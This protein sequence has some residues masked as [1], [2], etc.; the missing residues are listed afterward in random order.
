MFAVVLGLGNKIDI[1]EA[2]SKRVARDLA[3]HATA[4]GIAAPVE[5]DAGDI[6]PLVPA[7]LV[8]QRLQSR[9]IGAGFRAEH[10]VAGLP[11]CPLAVHAAGFQRLPAG[12]NVRGNRIG[13]IRLIQQ[14]NGAD[15][16]GD[17]IH[18]GRERVAEQSGDAKGDIDARPLQFGKRGDSK[19]R[20][21]AGNFF[22]QRPR[23]DQRQYLRHVVAAGA[24]VRG[25]PGRQRDR[26]RPFA[27]LL[28]VS[29]HQPLRGQPPD[30]PCRRRRYRANVN[31]KEIPSRR[32]HVGPSP[33]RRA[34]R[35]GT[36]EPPV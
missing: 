7:A 28:P 14:G 12:A 16:A 3:L 26:A 22:P 18:L 1:R 31:R 17:D 27:G 36:N 25:A 21:A 8:D 34:G 15:R 33:R 23:P 5:I 20:H 24:H 9:A 2:A 10:P 32:Q 35:T 30:P 4:I 29:F 19:S 6:G 11:L 13:A